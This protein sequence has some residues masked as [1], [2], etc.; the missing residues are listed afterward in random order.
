MSRYTKLLATAKINFN[1]EELIYLDFIIYA[2]LDRKER[3]E[4]SKAYY[5]YFEIH[6]EEFDE[7][8]DKLVKVRHD[9]AK[10]L[11]FNNFTELGYIRMDRTDYNPEMVVNLEKTNIRIYSTSL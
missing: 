5:N 2:I 9:M 11:G 8:Y 7:I 6:E 10:K 1:N 3:K 4:A